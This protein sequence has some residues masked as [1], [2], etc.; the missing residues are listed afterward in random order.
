M[1][2]LQLQ[3]RMN[4]IVFFL[5]IYFHY[6]METSP[7]VGNSTSELS[8]AL[9]IL[10]RPADY[11]YLIWIV[12]YLLLGRWVIIST[13]PK[14]QNKKMLENLGWW[15]IAVCFLNLSWLIMW[16]QAHY[17]ITLLLLTALLVTLLF[18]YAKIAGEPHIPFLYRLSFSIFIGWITVMTSVN[19]AVLLQTHFLSALNIHPEV[20]PILMLLAGTFFALW[21]TMRHKDTAYPLVFIWVYISIGIY[22]SAYVSIVFTS[23]MMVLLLCSASVYSFRCNLTIAYKNVMPR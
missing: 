10:F 17:F 11:A 12:I 9:P 6:L 13:F 7:H 14:L 21:F 8:H 18:L 1:K 23:A 16:Y 15:F 4:L 5:M 19:S 22:Q 20:W 3:A 2:H